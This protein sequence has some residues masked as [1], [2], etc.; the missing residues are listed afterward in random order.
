MS[1]TYLHPKVKLKIKNHF[2]SHNIE[3][4]EFFHENSDVHEKCFWSYFCFW[5]QNHKLYFNADFWHEN[6]KYFEI[7]ADRYTLAKL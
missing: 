2:K 7:K 3:S 6:F 5:A 4:W 1:I